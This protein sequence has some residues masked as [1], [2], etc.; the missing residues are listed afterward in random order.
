M[1]NA[2][3]PIDPAFAAVQS[4]VIATSGT[5][6]PKGFCASDAAN[7]PDVLRLAAIF[8]FHAPAVPSIRSPTTRGPK[9]QARSSA[10]APELRSIGTAQ[11][12]VPTLAATSCRRPARN[13]KKGDA[14]SLSGLSFHHGVI[15]G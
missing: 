2:T 6:C 4:D 7:H 15:R 10:G 5:S 3:A 9:P 1:F 13:A 14:N 11:A 12:T 8:Q